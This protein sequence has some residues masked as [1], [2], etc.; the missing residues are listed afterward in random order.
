MQT[1]VELFQAIEDHPFL[2][3]FGLSFVMLFLLLITTA[4]GSTAAVIVFCLLL[5]FSIFFIILGI[6]V[7]SFQKRARKNLVLD[8]YSGIVTVEKRA[9]ENHVILSTDRYYEVYNKYVPASATFT[10]ATVGGVTTGGWDVQE[11]HY[12]T[13]EIKRT[14]KW[15]IFYRSEDRKKPFVAEFKLNQSD[16]LLA[17]QDPFLRQ[18][19]VGSSRDRCNFR[20]LFRVVSSN[21]KYADDYLE[22]T[23]DV[24]GASNMVMPDMTKTMLTREE[25]ERVIAFLCGE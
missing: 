21:K 9:K 7:T 15:A 1:I 12:T 8:N 6:K 4:G 18:F 22:K 25:T 16:L 14:E 5:V 17:G 20:P 10:A 23:H 3:G 11:A 24:Y 19:V 2:T 13:G